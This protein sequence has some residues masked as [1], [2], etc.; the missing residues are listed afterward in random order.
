MMSEP[1]RLSLK[2]R[3]KLLKKTISK[4]LLAH[5]I[6]ISSKNSNKELG[7]WL[8]QIISNVNYSPAQIEQL[9][10]QIAAKMLKVCQDQEKVNLDKTVIQF[11]S[12]NFVIDFPETDDANIESTNNSSPDKLS[13]TETNLAQQTEQKEVIEET[14]L[15]ISSSLPSEFTEVFD[16]HLESSFENAWEKFNSLLFEETYS[17]P[18]PEEITGTSDINGLF[19]LSRGNKGLAIGNNS[20]EVIDLPVAKMPVLDPGIYRELQSDLLMHVGN[21]DDGNK[22]VTKWGNEDRGGIQINPKTIL[23]FVLA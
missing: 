22:Y 8:K 5:Q 13:T 15:A 18:A 23:L 21:G 1:D 11:I 14:P 6:T 17:R 9:A 12:Q 16:G 20:D 4:E 19:F 3:T 10:Q 2:A 7:F